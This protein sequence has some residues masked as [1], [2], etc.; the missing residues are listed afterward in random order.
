MTEIPDEDHVL[1]EHHGC[2]ECGGGEFEIAHRAN[3]AGD[4]IR[5]ADPDCNEQWTLAPRFFGC[6]FRPEV[7]SG[8]KEIEGLRM[9]LE[10][11]EALLSERDRQRTDL[12]VECEQLR[13]QVTTLQAEAEL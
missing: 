3:N 12:L 13:N 5:C 7:R 2:P 1:S 6:P 9:A 11:A 8:A 10:R 4:V